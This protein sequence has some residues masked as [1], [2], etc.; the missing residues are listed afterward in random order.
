VPPTTRSDGSVVWE[1]EGAIP[2]GIDV[3]VITGSAPRP[4]TGSEGEGLRLEVDGESELFLPGELDDG[5]IEA[6]LDLSD[7]Q[8]TVAL[9]HHAS[10]PCDGIAVSVGGGGE[11][12]L[13][14]RDDGRTIESGRVELPGGPFTLT[15]SAAGH[16][17]K[18]AVD[19]RV[20]V[21]GHADPGAGRRVGLLVS[22]VGTLGVRRIET[23]L[24]G[25]EG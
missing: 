2:E 17:L 4:A 1:P 22:G 13:L 6:R 14:A 5:V 24:A 3:E 11:V 9:V 21:H 25:E 12:R 15:A 18:G 19:G 10:G 20:I 7:L 16:H 23:H 8:G